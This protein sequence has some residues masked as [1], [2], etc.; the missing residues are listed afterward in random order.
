MGQTLE[1]FFDYG[2][3]YSYLAN[4]RLTELSER[5]GVEVVHRPML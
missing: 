4:H 3:P 2:S 5:T 1:F